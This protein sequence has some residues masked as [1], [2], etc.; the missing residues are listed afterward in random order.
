[1]SYSTFVRLIDC[2]SGT[3]RL[4]RCA[5]DRWFETDVERWLSEEQGLAAFRSRAGCVVKGCSSRNLSGQAC[6]EADEIAPVVQLLVIDRPI[7]CRVRGSFNAEDR[8]TL[9]HV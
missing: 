3:E 4:A 5:R 9:L 2:E 8:A 1:M 6:H 7:A